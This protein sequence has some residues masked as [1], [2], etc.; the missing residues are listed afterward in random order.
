MLNRR[1]L[2]YT[3][4]AATLAA[5]CQPVRA[6]A[7]TTIRV[8]YLHGLA[9]DAHLW[10]AEHLGTFEAQGLEL[11]LI[12]F[13]TGLE[14]YQALA[15]GSLDL[16]TTGAVISNFPARG[17]GKAF[18]INDEEFGTAQLWVHPESG[19][20]TI[21]DLKGQKIATTRGT[22]AHYFLFRALQHNGLDPTQDIEIVHQQMGNAVTAFI[23]GSVPAV[24]TWM[25]FDGSIAKSSPDAVKLADASQ[26][27][28][29][30]VLNGWSASNELYA[31]NKELLRRFIRAWLPA[32][33]A[34]VTRPQ[35]LLP[36]LQPAR[37]KEF[38]L[39]QLQ[40]QYDAV[41][42]RP[43][44]EWATRYRDGSVTKILNDVTAFNVAAGAFTDPLPAETYFDPSLLQDVLAQG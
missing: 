44:E 22:T 17:Q 5:T 36:V 4:A 11:E 28:D 37:Y 19:I 39:A 26:F 16:V 29:A 8:G 15:G 12:Q 20:K 43:A 42:W 31:G 10:T 34:L 1:A 21:A 25:P 41:H 14:A 24:A 23:A 6:A 13:V 32:N 38:T 30:A 9:A 35:E 2:L 3:G 18:L 33:E 40:S 7:P 27:A